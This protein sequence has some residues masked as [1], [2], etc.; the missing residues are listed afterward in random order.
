MVG[1]VKLDVLFGI[2]SKWNKSRNMVGIVRL[3][4]LYVFENKWNKSSAGAVIE[5]MWLEYWRPALLV[6]TNVVLSSGQ[7]CLEGR[8]AQCCQD[9]LRL[10]QYPFIYKIPLI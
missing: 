9:S 10:G 2:K 4:N 5:V 6:L 8:E 3:D 1:I 7:S